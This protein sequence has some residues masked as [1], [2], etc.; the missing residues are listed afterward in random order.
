MRT[1]PS[2]RSGSSDECCASSMK[3]RSTAR[4]LHCDL[5]IE[6]MRPAAGEEL[7][8]TETCEREEYGGAYPRRAGDERPPREVWW[9]WVDV[10]KASARCSSDAHLEDPGA[11]EESL[12]KL[13][14][15]NSRRTRLNGRDQ[16]E[17][18]IPELVARRWR[19][20]CAQELVCGTGSAS[21]EH[22]KIEDELE[23]AAGARDDHIDDKDGLKGRCRSQMEDVGSVIDPAGR[24]RLGEPLA[25]AAATWACADVLNNILRAEQLDGEELSRTAGRRRLLA[26]GHV[27][28]VAHVE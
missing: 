23:D 27:M 18:A 20:E 5:T 22:P 16:L 17:A 21:I 26:V 6:T 19:T 1:H 28:S 15:K 7:Q 25:L 14:A 12:L 3:A 10:T 24:V 4:C 2:T 11:S 8:S 13:L 9:Q